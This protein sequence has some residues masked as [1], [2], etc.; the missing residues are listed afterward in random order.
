MPDAGEATVPP[1]VRC[2][3]ACPHSAMDEPAHFPEGSARDR[4]PGRRFAVGAARG[5]GTAPGDQPREI[6]WE[7]MR[8]TCGGSSA[9]T[10]AT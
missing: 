8:S 9:R 5:A 10:H 7:L 6:P 2:A 3:R 4:G 1:R